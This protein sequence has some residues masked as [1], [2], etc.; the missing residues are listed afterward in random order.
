MGA[1]AQQII[2]DTITAAPASGKITRSYDK[3][4]AF[5]ATPDGWVPKASL[6][7]LTT[8]HQNFINVSGTINEIHTVATA[9]EFN[10]L[11]DVA[12]DVAVLTADIWSGITKVSASLGIAI[13]L[14]QKGDAFHC[15]GTRWHLNDD[16]RRIRGGGASAILS[17]D[18]HIGDTLPATATDPDVFLL[19]ADITRLEDTILSRDNSNLG[20]LVKLSPTQTTKN[21]NALVAPIVQE[22]TSPNDTIEG[23][24]LGWHHDNLVTIGRKGRIAVATRVTYRAYNHRERQIYADFDNDGLGKC[25]QGNI[26]GFGQILGGGSNESF[27]KYFLVD[28]NLP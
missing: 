21:S 5:I 2:L 1:I 24:L 25:I 3:G 26:G 19:T 8:K 6:T 18:L 9:A 16:I 12:S 20:Y 11:S 22:A 27:G 17:G 28:L 23:V 10:A 7:Y 13:D 4:T 15:N 14:G